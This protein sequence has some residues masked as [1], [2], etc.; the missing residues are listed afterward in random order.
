MHVHTDSF[1]NVFG[2]NLM[3]VDWASGRTDK[4]KMELMPLALRRPI[5]CPIALLLAS[6]KHYSRQLRPKNDG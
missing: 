2:I 3:K 4:W 6:P 1:F 5:R